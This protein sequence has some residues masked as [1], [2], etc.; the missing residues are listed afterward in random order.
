M[1]TRL[2]IVQGIQLLRAKE[3]VVLPDLRLLKR[4]IYPCPPDAPATPEEI[5]QRAD[6]AN[7]LGGTVVFDSNREGPFGIYE[8]ELASGEI[9][10]LVAGDVHA[11]Y[12]DVSP[13][14]GKIVYAQALSTERTASSSI[15]LS[16]GETGAPEQIALNGTFPTFNAD[17]SAV[18]FERNRRQLVRVDLATGAEAVIFPGPDSS[19][20]SFAV[21]KPRVSPDGT[22]VLFTS[23]KGGRWNSWCA[24]LVDES[25]HHVVKGCEGTWY[26]DSMHAAWIKKSGPLG[27]VG[28][29][30]INVVTPGVIEV[31]QDGRSAFSH[32]YFPWITPDG[33]HLFFSAC[34]GYEHSHI[35]ARYQLF[36][37]TMATGVVTRLSFDGFTNRWARLRPHR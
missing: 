32:E 13:G 12:P 35:D 21:V 2:R 20:G 23:D 7:E 29:Y 31:V 10:R 18:Y 26:P 34:P 37:R 8:L 11:M 16:S 25:F 28:I 9:N 19:F 33:R 17:G 15:W 30:R 14:T 3:L 36:V 6:V 5:R 4:L 24:S 1:P 27:N 22:R